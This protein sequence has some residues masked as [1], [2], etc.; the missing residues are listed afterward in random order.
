MTG[1]PLPDEHHVLR[2]C[3]PSKIDDDGLPAVE[4]FLPRESD[5]FLSTNWMEYFNEGEVGDVI[6]Q[7]LVV[8]R[9]KLTI[10]GKGKLARLNVGEAKS[11]A[12]AAGYGNVN[13]EERPEKGDLSHAG[14]V[15]YA[16]AQLDVAA[17]LQ[18]LVSAEEGVYP[19][20]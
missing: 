18:S 17:V 2:Y 3:P 14:I 8:L 7:V 16:H 15:G 4:A 5:N 12:R 11:A 10:K 6:A 20:E 13:I 19:T 1:D 9:K